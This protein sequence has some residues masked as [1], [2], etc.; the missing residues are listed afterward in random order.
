VQ[1]IWAATAEAGPTPQPGAEAA[2]VL[3]AEF[4]PRPHRISENEGIFVKALLDGL[5][6]GQSVDEAGAAIDLPAIL[7]LLI[8]GRAITGAIE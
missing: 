6:L 1:T 7:S 2:L 5:S 3:R 8:S 4:D